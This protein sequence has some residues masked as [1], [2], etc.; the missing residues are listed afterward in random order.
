MEKI[1]NLKI[2]YQSACNEYVDIFHDVDSE[3]PKGFITDWYYDNLEF[4]DKAINYYSYTKGLRV[5]DI[6]NRKDNIFNLKKES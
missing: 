3:Q 6:E 4:K 1:K 2:K 5:K